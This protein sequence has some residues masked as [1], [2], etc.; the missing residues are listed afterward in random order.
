MVIHSL[1]IGYSS[2]KEKKKMKTEMYRKERK[3]K[4]KQIMGHDG[5]SQRAFKT[6]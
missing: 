2:K 1:H 5:Y 6:D 4:E 3:R